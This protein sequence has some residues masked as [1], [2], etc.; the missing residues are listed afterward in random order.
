MCLCVSLSKTNRAKKI[1]NERYKNK[2]FYK[3]VKKDHLSLY[4][5][6]QY[7]RGIHH[8]NVSWRDVHNR[9]PFGEY[10]QINHGIHVY[11]S[12]NKARVNC[13]PDSS[14]IVKVLCHINDLIAYGIHEDAAFTR[15]FYTGEI[16]PNE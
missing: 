3:V 14:I 8:A 12:L 6:Y 1:K 10:N 7:S 4:E 2:V 11:T 16:V 5:H 13:H 9:K 15:I